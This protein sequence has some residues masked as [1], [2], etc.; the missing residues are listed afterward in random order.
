MF[1]RIYQVV[2]QIPSGKVTTYGRIARQVKINDARI[3]GWALHANINPSVPCH[4]VV[5]QA[6]R[7]AKN[8]GFG[9]WQKQKQKLI[10]EKVKFTDQYCVDLKQAMVFC[11]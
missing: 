5:N 7:L 9:G 6:G 2:Q 11:S 1:N 3:V 8:Y 10:S 4:R